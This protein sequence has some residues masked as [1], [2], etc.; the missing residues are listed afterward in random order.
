[1]DFIL[2]VTEPWWGM[3]KRLGVRMNTVL[4]VF[5]HAGGT[6]GSLQDPVNGRVTYTSMT[7]RSAAHYYCNIGY[8][9][10]GSSRRICRGSRWS[11]REPTCERKYHYDLSLFIPL[12]LTHRSLLMTERA[13]AVNAAVATYIFLYLTLFHPYT[14]IIYTS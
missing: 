9:I 5:F 2:Q 14:N 13:G 12:F 7:I 3:E 8:I 11:G 1:M 4:W 10:S 6:C